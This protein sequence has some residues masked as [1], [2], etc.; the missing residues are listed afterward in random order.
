MIWK[1][2]KIHIWCLE[3]QQIHGNFVGLGWG[4]SGWAPALM[5]ASTGRGGGSTFTGSWGSA[6]R[7]AT[8][9]QPT[10]A[11]GDGALPAPSGTLPGGGRLVVF[12]FR[13]SSCGL[14]EWQY[15]R[16]LRASA[17]PLRFTICGHPCSWLSKAR[18]L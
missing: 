10:E 6:K 15:P 7:A 16:D 14:A 8:R 11:P 13:G 18:I 2:I 12:G 5:A 9:T 17:C 3:T 1:F 4:S